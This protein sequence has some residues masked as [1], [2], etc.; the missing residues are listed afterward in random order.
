MAD[1]FQNFGWNW[2][3]RSLN[4]F[5]LILLQLSV[6]FCCIASTTHDDCEAINIES[7]LGEDEVNAKAGAELQG[8]FGVATGPEGTH[9]TGGRCG[10]A[11]TI[12]AIKEAAM[13][14]EMVKWMTNIR[15]HLHKHPELSW[16]EFETS[17]FIR[18]HLDEL[19]I[20]YEYP[21]AKTGVVGI[22]GSGNGPVIA[23]RADMDALPIQESGDSKHKSKIPTKMHACGHDAHVTILLAAAKILRSRLNLLQGT[24]RLL[25]QP[26]EEG[27]A[28][29]KVMVEEGALGKAEAIFGLHVSP[30]IPTGTVALKPGP[31]MAASGLWEA[32]IYGKGGHAAMPQTLVDPVVAAA[33]TVLVLQQLVSREADPLDSQV[34]SVSFLQG[35]KAYNVVPES[36]RM[37]GTFRAFSS[38]SFS[39]LKQRIEEVIVN[40]AAVHRCQASVTFDEASH[41]FYP[42]TINDNKLHDHVHPMATKL[43]GKDNVLAAV[44]VMGAEDFAFYMQSIPGYYMVLGMRN[45]TAGSIFSGHTSRYVFDDNALPH[46]AALIA[47]TAETY[48]GY[49]SHSQKK[50][51]S[52]SSDHSSS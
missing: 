49:L 29:A 20:P 19:N 9:G 48:L 21:V 45:E 4:P 1:F 14:E 8:K 7:S 47:S 11:D 5:L 13:D 42:A 39:R 32:N 23:L 46:G 3:G 52:C 31:L 34:V 16:E 28:G 12:P 17:A 10:G 43:F 22:L 6:C 44:P 50:S 26:A 33:A 38:E 25:F 15:R 35:G 27:G 18:K 2:W 37:G 51:A 30:Y 24:V 36:V 41:P 40:Q